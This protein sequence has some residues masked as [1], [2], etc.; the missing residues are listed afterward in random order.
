MSINNLNE[1]DKKNPRRAQTI[2]T[3]EEIEKLNI[4]IKSKETK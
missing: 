1:M 2:M 3:Q 4:Y